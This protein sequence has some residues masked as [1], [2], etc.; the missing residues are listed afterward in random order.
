MSLFR[1]GL[2]ILATTLSFSAAALPIYET[3]RPDQFFSVDFKFK[4]DTG[5]ADVLMVNGGATAL[6]LLGSNI[7]LFVNNKL[8][9]SWLNPM[10]NTF[11]VFTD[12]G[13]FYTSWGTTADLTDIFNGSNARLEF[14]PIFDTSVAN[15]FVNYQLD[16]FGAAQSLA[17]GSLS[18]QL[19]SPKI[20]SYGVYDNRP[21]A[22]VPEPGS[23]GLLA[24]GLIGLL[25]RRRVSLRAEL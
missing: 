10:T 2:L 6:G 4:A 16:F 18:D 8:L 21:H 19:I 7:N 12:P 1:I 3:V 20:K 13:S 23:A 25:W 9:A 22:S 14:H 5:D 17:D 11:A 24:A 15:A